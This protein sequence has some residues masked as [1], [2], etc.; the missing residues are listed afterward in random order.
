VVRQT[1]FTAV[2]TV[3][4]KT[5]EDAVTSLLMSSLTKRD[6]EALLRD[7]DSDPV[8]ALLSALTKVWLVSE[9][10]W[11]DAVDRLQVD[12]ETRAKLRGCSVDA[13]DDLAKQ[14]VENR[15]LQQ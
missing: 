3:E 5:H 9:F 14:L 10:T 15:G 6:V 1:A 11:N 13:L 4:V 7:Y 12:E 8:A 2:V